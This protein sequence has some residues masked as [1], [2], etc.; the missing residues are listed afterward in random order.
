MNPKKKNNSSLNKIPDWEVK[1]YENDPHFKKK[2]EEAKRRI[3]K[4]GI[5]EE[6]LKSKK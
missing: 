1:L 5:P 6:F 2:H 3:E 4:Y